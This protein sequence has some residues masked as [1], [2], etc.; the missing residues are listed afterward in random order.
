MIRRVYVALLV[1][2][3][4]VPL[5]AQTTKGWRLRVD[6][7]ENAADPDA[8]GA[9]RFVG[10]GSGFHAT[11]PQAATFWNPAN[12]VVGDYTLKGTFTLMAPSP[13]VNYYGLVFGAGDLEGPRQNYLYFMVAQD[14]TWLI[15]HRSGNISTQDL[16]ARMPSDAVKTP[17]SRGKSTNTLEVRVKSS[18][19]DYVVNGTVVHSTPRSGPTAKTDGVYGLRVNHLLEVQVDGFAISKQ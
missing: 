19:I 17:D 18:A 16:S 3:T 11:N 12:T 5:A 1:L 10:T 14:G 6:R 8:A 4:A 7:S 13:H 15:K 9:I 2:L